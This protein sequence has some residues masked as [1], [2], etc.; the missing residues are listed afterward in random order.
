MDKKRE[1]SENEYR[2]VKGKGP[3]IGI[4]VGGTRGRTSCCLKSGELAKVL[5]FRGH[6]QKLCFKNI[7]CQLCLVSP[8][9]SSTRE[10]REGLG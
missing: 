4:E 10:R 6:G 2:G 9:R 1:Y 8:K 5:A 3:N 7:L